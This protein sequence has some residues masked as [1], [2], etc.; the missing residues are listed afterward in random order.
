[1][2]GHN[3]WWKAYRQ[4]SRRVSSFC[5]LSHSAGF[6]ITRLCCC[7]SR[8]AFI[9]AWLGM[10]RLTISSVEFHHVGT[11]WIS[12]SC[13]CPSFTCSAFSSAMFAG[14]C[15]K[16]PTSFDTWLTQQQIRCQRDSQWCFSVWRE[17]YRAYAHT[18]EYEPQHIACTV[19][20]DGCD[21]LLN[22]PL[23]CYS[24]K[25]FCTCL[26]KVTFFCFHYS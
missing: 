20:P 9:A 18:V 7:W 10:M 26:S 3:I 24:L 25:L 13:C 19:S 17:W 23:A 4:G 14:L 16:C 15:L 1:M 8:V 11:S 5:S 21:F 12:G 6:S 22:F 2:N